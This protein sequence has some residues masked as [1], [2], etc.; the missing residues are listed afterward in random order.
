MIIA[1]RTKVTA[2]SQHYLVKIVIYG[3]TTK[4][5]IAILTLNSESMIRK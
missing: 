1:V 2:P 5:K 4:T 3:L